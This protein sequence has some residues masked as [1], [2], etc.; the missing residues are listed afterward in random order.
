MES[1]P[2][3]TWKEVFT[4]PLVVNFP[5]GSLAMQLMEYISGTT[6]ENSSRL[7]ASFIVYASDDL[8]QSSLIRDSNSSIEVAG[9]VVS[10]T[11]EGLDLVNL[12]EPLVIEIQV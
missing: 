7:Q 2:D 3:F 5:L 4:G 12:T 10:L 11:V 9:P 6:G 1:L 8:F